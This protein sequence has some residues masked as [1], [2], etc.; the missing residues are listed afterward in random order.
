MWAGGVKRAWSPIPRTR[1]ESPPGCLQLLEPG[2]LSIGE[3]FQ[4]D[5]IAGHPRLQHD[6]A[7]LDW[8]E[9]TPGAVSWRHHP[10]SKWPESRE[11][12]YGATIGSRSSNGR[13][14]SR[15]RLV[16]ARGKSIAGQS[17]QISITS[18]RPAEL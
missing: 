10:P 8:S 2:Y 18:Q 11:R 9:A 1:M 7:R 4:G 15:E 17:P 3:E 14:G 12:S 6:T 16:I 5:H 13:L